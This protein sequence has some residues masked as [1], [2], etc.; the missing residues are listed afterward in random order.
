MHKYLFSLGLFLA[1][2]AAWADSSFSLGAG[3]DYS[4]GK[5]GGDTSTNIL[6]IPV[7]GTYKNDQLTLKLTV[8]YIH[9][10]SV[11]NI[12]RGMGMI[13]PAT[14]SKTTTQAG[15]GDITAAAAYTFYDAGSLALDLVGKV[16]FGTASAD[17]GLGTGEND[18]AAQVDG[19]Y[20]INST[21]LFATAGYK[22]VG[23]PSGIEVNN[24]GYGTAGV[25]QKLD[26]S[27]SAGMM[28]DAAQRITA[29]TPGTRELTLFLSHQVK[30]DLSWRASLLKGLSDASADYGVGFMLTG[31]Y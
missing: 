13:R 25:S 1:P 27:Y 4:T 5:Y 3:F 15:L 22:I 30:Q 31:T 18:Y 9:V 12:V 7:T 19:Y 10:T 6:Y 14:T 29:L 20:L 28:L 26:K 24:I 17:K 23:A 2:P 16:K 8:P 21:T 11:G